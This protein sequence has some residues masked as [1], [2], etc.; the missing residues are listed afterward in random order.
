MDYRRKTWRVLRYLLVNG[1]GPADMIGAVLWPDR[2]G[3]VCAVQGG[4]DYAAQMFLGRLR[5]Q[6]LVRVRNNPDDGCSIW[7]LTSKGEKWLREHPQ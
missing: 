2:K 5:K 4:G 6:G 1:M 3:R 7:V